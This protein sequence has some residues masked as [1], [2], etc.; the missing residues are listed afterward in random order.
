MQLS[1]G[2]QAA[3]DECVWQHWLF[4]FKTVYTNFSIP[5]SDIGPSK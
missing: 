3:C 2:W 4:Y 5:D 1:G